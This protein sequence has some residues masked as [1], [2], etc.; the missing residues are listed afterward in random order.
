[1]IQATSGLSRIPW[2]VEVAGQ[3]VQQRGVGGRVRVAEIIDRL[4]DPPAEQVEPDPVGQVAAELAIVARQPVGQYGRGRCRR[5]A[6]RSALP[7]RTV[8][9]KHDA[10]P[11][12]DHPRRV[13]GQVDDLVAV[14]LVLVEVV[15]ADVVELLAR[16]VGEERGQAVV[17]VLGPGVERVVVASRTLEPDAQEDLGDALGGGRRVAVGPV[18]AGRRVLPGRAQAADDPA[19]HLVQRHVARDLVAEP[20]L[21]DPGPFL[22]HGLLFVP[23]QIGPLQ[24]PEVGELGPLDQPVDQLVRFV[25]SRSARKARVSAGS[26][27]R[28]IASR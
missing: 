26:G 1:M 17:I 25:G 21:E 2:L 7:R 11:R 14:D 20:A 28:P 18:E 6:R 9:S 8:G 4:D 3:G 19:D 23:E 24:R 27:S 16:D 5:R 22:A 15:L 12:L 13:T 10:G